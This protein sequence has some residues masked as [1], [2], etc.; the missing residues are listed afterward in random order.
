MPETGRPSQSPDLFTKFLPSI[1]ERC[2]AII[3]IMT[4]ELGSSSTARRNSWIPMFEIYVF[5]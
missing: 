2:S 4:G 5:W 1:K 3:N